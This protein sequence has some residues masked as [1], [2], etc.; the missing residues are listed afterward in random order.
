DQAERL[1]FAHGSAFTTEPLEAYATEVAE[2][3]PVDGPAIYTVSAGPGASE[4]APKLARAYPLARGE[5]ARDVVV[6]RHG[7]YH[8]NTLAALDL[9]GRPP[10][11]RPYKSCSNRPW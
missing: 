8:G 7:S 9:S 2:V 1:S 3:L 6:A 11:R 4:T 10:L 5:P